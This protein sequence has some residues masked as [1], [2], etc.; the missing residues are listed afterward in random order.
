MTRFNVICTGSGIHKWGK[1]WIEHMLSHLNCKF[2]YLTP[3]DDIPLLEKCIVVTNTT[4]SYFYIRR[5]QQAHLKY[6]VILL[7][8]ECLDSSLAFLN[9]PDCMFLARNYVHPG[10]YRHF[11]VFHFGLGYKNEFE[12][13]ANPRRTASNREF[14]WSFT[15]SL[16]ADREQA[17]QIF[18]QF[19]PNFT[20]LVEKFD[21]PEYLTTRKYAQTL[22]DSIFVLAPAGGASNDSFRIYEAL[23]C[24]AIPVVMRN[25]PHLQIMPSYWHG[26]F[27]GS[28]L[29]FVMA[30]TW[31]E[32]AEQVR[33]MIDTNEVES[34]RRDCMD[35]WRSWKKSWRLEFEKRAASLI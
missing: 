32:A 20:Y 34:V 5:L 28:D 35:F 8:D 9:N 31:E 18:S 33:S 13:Y 19:E 4:E 23:E 2:H 7:S 15:G 24:G 6:G 10:C 1:S 26:I 30:D 11:K 22:N 25:T 14:L 12:K 3:S 16:K 29:P 21:D 27:P 17:I